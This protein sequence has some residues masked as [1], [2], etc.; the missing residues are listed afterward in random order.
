MIAKSFARIHKQNLVNNGIIP[1]VFANAA[2]Y[3]KIHEGD[4][5]A[6]NSPAQLFILTQNFGEGSGEF[7]NP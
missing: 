5:L 2:D 4:E 3:E 7:L 6:L 1:L